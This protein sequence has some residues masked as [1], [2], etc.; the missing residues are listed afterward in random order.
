MFNAC[1]HAVFVSVAG[2]T[3]ILVHIYSILLHFENSNRINVVSFL[4]HSLKKLILFVV[5]LFVVCLLTCSCAA[6]SCIFRYGESFQIV[7]LVS[8]DGFIC[9]ATPLRDINTNPN[10]LMTSQWF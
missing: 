5:Y 10:G 7:W 6:S 4:V 1:T 8:Q 3:V 2:V 9:Q